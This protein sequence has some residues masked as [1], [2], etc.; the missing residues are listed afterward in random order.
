MTPS[1]EN[2]SHD[3]ILMQ[4][5]SFINQPVMKI[6]ALLTTLCLLPALAMSAQVTIEQCIDMAVANYPA[7][8]KYDLLQAANAIDLSDIN[9][10]WLPRISVYGQAT[11]QN[12]VPTFPKS[13]AGVLQQM[14]QPMRGLGKI[15]YKVGADMSQTIWD[16]GV[17]KAR[18]ELARGDEAA[19]RAA[20]DV[21][22]YAI[23]ERVENLYFAIL[24]T[25]EQ[26]DQNRIT[27][28][29]LMSNLIKLRTM[30]RNGTAMQSDADMVE[31]Q[32]LT[33]TQAIA[34]AQSA[35]NG[36]RDVLSIF[37]GDNLA[38]T[39]LERPSAIEPQTD[40]SDRP[41]LQLFAHQL[42]LNSLSNRLSDTELMPRVG[43]FAQAYYGYPGFNYFESMLNRNLS[44]NIM[45]GV[46]VSWTID[47][48]FTH[49]NKSRRTEI[50]SSYIEA[51]RDVF[52]FN[53]DMQ[54]ASNRAAIEGIRN[55]MKEDSRI[56]ELRAN[57][58]HAAESQL[59]N[60]VIDATA[61]LTKIS[62][63][64]IARLT[65]QLHEIQLI[66]EIYKLKYTLNR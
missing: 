47:A 26:I 14:G 9:K 55:V 5:H 22:L 12:I 63:E 48:F 27:Y 6:K 37:T 66:Q 60:G 65:A 10:S 34:A 21:E 45:A 11:G 35:A 29:L 2:S 62:D 3:Y 31:A 57:V 41:E 39:Q 46:K 36:Y 54:A 42:A 50:N 58:R 15:Q 8:K 17:S 23:R 19:R 20:L 28:D 18:R 13:L 49:K 44:F 16:G 64:N 38:D 24:L 4:P 53:T 43:L 33:L 51:D 1:C 61:L 56:I 32:A 40:S 30:V 7:I 52:L 59:E 25:E